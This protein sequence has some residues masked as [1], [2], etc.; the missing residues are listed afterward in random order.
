AVDRPVSSPRLGA[1][2]VE[3]GVLRVLLGP[4]QAGE[5]VDD[6]VDHRRRRGVRGLH[7]EGRD[8]FVQGFALGDQRLPVLHRGAGPAQQRPVRSVDPLP[9]GL[10]VDVDVHDLDRRVLEL[11]SGA[12]IEDRSPAQ[13]HDPRPVEQAPQR[14]AHDFAFDAP[15]MVLTAFDEDLRDHSVLFDDIGIGVDQRQPEAV[16]EQPPDRRLPGRGRAAEH[17]A[18]ERGGDRFQRWSRFRDRGLVHGPVRR[19]CGMA[20]TWP[21]RFRVVSVTESPPNYSTGASARPRATIAAATTPAAG[22]A[23]TSERWWWAFAASPVLTSTVDR[24][25]GTEAM[26]FIPARTRS[27][28]PVDIPPSVP[29]ARLLVRRNPSGP[30]SS[31]SW[32]L[33][34]GRFA[35]WK[36]S[37]TS[38]P[39]IAW[40]PMRAP[41]SRESSRRSQC[42]WDPSPDGRP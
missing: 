14:L 37:P 40:M 17:D 34:P 20:E 19:S 22:T 31:S 6:A 36:P 2:L 23:H 33:D 28:P 27:G 13:G 4:L 38:T 32:A 42:T 41:A 18:R 5:D 24:A 39:L 30:T 3:V 10:D 8:L 26:G 7:A 11:G 25:R 1:A 9:D 29:P 35:V 15:A 16:G 21:A 12:G